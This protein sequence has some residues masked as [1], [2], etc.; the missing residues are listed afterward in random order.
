M[1]RKRE[2]ERARGK[3]KTSMQSPTP[4]PCGRRVGKLCNNIIII[5]ENL[6]GFPFLIFFFLNFCSIPFPLRLC[7]L[8]VKSW[9]MG[10]SSSFLVP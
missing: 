6:A 10:F 5:S 2:R 1:K 3:G 9:L 4:N 7:E 8:R